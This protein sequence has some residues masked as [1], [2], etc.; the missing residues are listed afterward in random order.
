MDKELTNMQY[1]YIPEYVY[2]A[3]AKAEIN[4]AGNWQPVVSQSE[5]VFLADH[6][7]FSGP[8]FS[9]NVVFWSFFIL[10]LL[11]SLV[12]FKRHF[13]LMLLDFL[14]FLIYGLLGLFLLL[15]WLATDHHAAAW[16]LNLLWAWPFHLLI[17]PMLLKKGRPRWLNWYL[18]FTAAFGL[19]L[20]VCWVALPQALNLA[21]IPMTL[22]L[23]SRS[24]F[25]IM[26]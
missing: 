19:L 16:N 8:F 2:K 26:E 7:E 22:A 17:A 15:L 20:V 12:A 1:T 6:S 3:F 10:V 5:D 9:P 13:S 18:L 14:F 24:A 11:A 25:A 4:I 21:L 23:V